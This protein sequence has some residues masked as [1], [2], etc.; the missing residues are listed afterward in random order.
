MVNHRKGERRNMLVVDLIGSVSRAS[1]ASKCT[2]P[3]SPTTASLLF[4]FSP[5]SAGF[6]PFAH[7][8]CVASAWNRAQVEHLL[9]KQVFAK[10]KINYQG[11]LSL[12]NKII[13]ATATNISSLKTVSILCS[14]PGSF[15]SQEPLGPWQRYQLNGPVKQKI[16]WVVFQNSVFES[17]L[18]SK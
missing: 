10:N 16:C 15:F 5:A 7:D 13:A 11:Q 2:F 4:L 3:L 1:P 8:I 17:H 12:Q 14:I 18:E 6:F 9:A